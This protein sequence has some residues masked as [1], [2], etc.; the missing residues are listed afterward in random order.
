M[1]PRLTSSASEPPAAAADV[2]APGGDDD[3]AVRRAPFAANPQ[4]GARG[5]RTQQRIL[6]AA[7]QVFGEE[8]YYRCS[9]DRIAE[10]AGCSRASFYQYFS[11]KED[12]FQHLTGQ[13]ARHLDAST[14]ALE[15]LT[16]DADGRRALRAWIGRH[17][18]IYVR[19]EP[20]FHAFE[21]AQE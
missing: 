21:A 3:S 17:G 19:Y 10:R 20:V 13:V 6:E 12:V 15:P 18:D 5:Q 16:P 4:V 11:G 1:A 7:L 9:I 14:E 2:G 8:G